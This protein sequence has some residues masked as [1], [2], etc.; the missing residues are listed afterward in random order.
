[1]DVEMNSTA[2]AHLLAVKRAYD[3]TEKY[4]KRFKDSPILPV[5]KM[6]LFSRELERRRRHIDT[7]DTPTEKYTVPVEVF[8]MLA[9]LDICSKDFKRCGAQAVRGSQ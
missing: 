6:V 9:A 1:M 8:E 4:C 2:L 5:L 7:D 3:K